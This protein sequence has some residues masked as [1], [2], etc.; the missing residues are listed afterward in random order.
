M[1][2]S[3]R[4]ADA[5]ALE[6]TGLSKRFGYVQAVAD[7][8]FAVAPGRITGFLGPNGAGK[9][10]T[11][12]ILLGLVKA[13]KGTATIGGQRYQDLVDPIRCVGALLEATS[14]HPARRAR[15]H[16]RMCAR[17]ASIETTR[18][19][20]V[21][22]LVGL[23]EA[24]RRRVG[25]YSLGM[26]QRLGLAAAL[27][28]NPPVLILDEPANG[29]DPQGIAWLREF[30]RYLAGQG[31]TV[32]VSSHLLAEMAQTVDD[33]VII[34]GGRAR[35]AG[36]LASLT[37]QIR[38]AMRVRTPEADRL[39]G[40][41]VA[42]HWQARR[43]S[44]DLVL[45]DDVGPEQLGPV[46]ARSQIVVYELVHERTDLESVFLSLTGPE[47]APPPPATAVAIT[48]TGPTTPPA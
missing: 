39:L 18:V 35:A 34:A 46:L 48:P 19:D 25:G 41:L 15:D 44:E 47:I 29:L 3:G 16:L 45:V 28:G 23:K 4:R 24:A 30:L 42:A 27:L 31:H 2:S 37:G 6:V 9:T 11:L 32:L 43:L 13:T 22:E 21:L 10:T 33:V 1:D 40:V 8:D 38:S 12:R 5:V 7:L 26:R 14:F 20:E 17:A 36:P